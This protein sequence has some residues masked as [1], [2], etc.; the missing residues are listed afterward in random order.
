MQVNQKLEIELKES[1]LLSNVSLSI[2]GVE[3]K[4]TRLLNLY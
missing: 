1:F 3:S 4:N 2:L